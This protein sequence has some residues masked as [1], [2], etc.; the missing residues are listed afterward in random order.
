MV[1][2]SL[3]AREGVEGVE[4]VVS[5]QFRVAKEPNS[6]T[7]IGNEKRRRNIVHFIHRGDSSTVIVFDCAACLSV[8]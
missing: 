3:R 4:G 2:G 8:R 7:L 1:P 6:T 5:L